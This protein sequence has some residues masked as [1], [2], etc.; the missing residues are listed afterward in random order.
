MF[1]QSRKVAMPGSTRRT[2]LASALG[3]CLIALAQWPS[4]AATAP[5]SLPAVHFVGLKDVRGLMTAAHAVGDEAVVGRALHPAANYT[6]RTITGKI[7]RASDG[8]P[9]AY[10]CVYA[11]ELLNNPAL[12]PLDSSFSSQVIS[13]ASCADASGN[14]S[15]TLPTLPSAAFTG[16]WLV[17]DPRDSSLVGTYV[18]RTDTGT[19]QDFALA[20]ATGTVKGSVTLGTD[21]ISYPLVQVTDASGA[22]VLAIGVGDGVGSYTLGIANS[23]QVLGARVSATGSANL[24]VSPDLSEAP[25]AIATIDIPPNT[26]VTAPTLA[27][28]AD[29]AVTAFATQDGSTGL[30]GQLVFAQCLSGCNASMVATTIETGRF[31]FAV[32]AGASFDFGYGGSIYNGALKT[33]LNTIPDSLLTPPGDAPVVA[34]Q[35][36][37]LHLFSQGP[38][39][40]TNNT[41]MAW[42]GGTI[43]SAPYGFDVA[44]ATGSWNH[45]LGAFSSYSNTDLDGAQVKVAAGKTVCLR[46]RTV[47]AFAVDG[48]TNIG[49]PKTTCATAPVDDRTMSASPGW[50]KVSSSSAYA[51]TLTT[52]TRAKATLTLKNA[53]GSQLAIVWARAPQG[54]IFTVAVNGK[55]LRTVNTKGASAAKQLTVLTA[56]TLR[57]A[58]VVITATSKAPVSVDGVAVL[59]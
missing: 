9:V 38:L 12:Q 35:S 14:Y 30:P 37:V 15:L 32:P 45:A 13:P 22:N 11:V 33:G 40:L 18:T 59:P 49:N 17:V 58:T 6:P 29:S 51:K 16:P 20:A 34:G 44:A 55:T 43:E 23:S 46:V 53:T 5:R 41:L 39:T 7:T 28:P 26:T 4:T 19:T 48:G 54:G 24:A 27:M 8:S 42:L 56:K 3:L 2:L 50:R 47:T 10:A 1:V 57:N 31:T 21:G 36:P 52:S 25:G